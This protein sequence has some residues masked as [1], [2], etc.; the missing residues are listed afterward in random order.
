MNSKFRI[1]KYRQ[2]D[3]LYLRLAGDFNDISICELL[4]VLKDNCS[5]ANQVVIQ[6]S[7]LR[8]VSIS[9]IGRDVF[10]KNLNNLYNSSIDVKFAELDGNPLISA[11]A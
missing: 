6:T 9:G 10:N 2:S 11:S 3:K 8:N 7:S 1:S 5:G 4:D